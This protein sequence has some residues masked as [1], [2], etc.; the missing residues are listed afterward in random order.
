MIFFLFLSRPSAV[1]ARAFRIIIG[2]ERIL[3]WNGRPTD[4]AKI[5]TKEKQ[6]QEYYGKN[7]KEGKKT[8]SPSTERARGTVLRART[9][10]HTRAHVRSLNKAQRSADRVASSVPVFSRPSRRRRRRLSRA[11]G[12][13]ST[14]AAAMRRLCAQEVNR[15]QSTPLRPRA[16]LLNAYATHV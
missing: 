5:I 1:P 11:R 8:I 13:T 3:L 9:S 14:A 10:G 12:E 16:G 2:S 15:K 4:D 6:Q 7:I